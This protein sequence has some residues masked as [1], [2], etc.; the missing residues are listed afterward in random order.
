MYGSNF[1]NKMES[2]VGIKNKIVN[3]VTETR[4]VKFNVAMHGRRA[5]DVVPVK[6]ADGIELERNIRRRIADADGSI[7]II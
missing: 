5:G 4:M 3:P 6:F 1:D 2:N 7:E